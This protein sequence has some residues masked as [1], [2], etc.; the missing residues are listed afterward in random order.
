L[1]N[2]EAFYEKVCETIEK[3]EKELF[4]GEPTDGLKVLYLYL[5]CFESTN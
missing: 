4:E 5:F 3:S 2:V 1:E